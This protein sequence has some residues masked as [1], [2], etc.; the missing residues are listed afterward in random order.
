[1]LLLAPVLLSIGTFLASYPFLFLCVLYIQS[2]GR[3]WLRRHAPLLRARGVASIPFP[4]TTNTVY[5]ARTV[6]G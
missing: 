1:M 2:K 3:G 6:L 4:Q 5:R